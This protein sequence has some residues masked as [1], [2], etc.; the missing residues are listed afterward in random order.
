MLFTD[1]LFEV[2][3]GDDEYY[4]ADRLLDAV[5]KRMHLAAADLFGEVMAEIRGSCISGR[6]A[7]DMCMLGVELRRIGLTDSSQKVA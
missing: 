7:D 2:E 6:F 3:T 4:G 1:G 5:R